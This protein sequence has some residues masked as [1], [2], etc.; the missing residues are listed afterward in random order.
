MNRQ[1]QPKIQQEK[2]YL[3]FYDPALTVFY[4]IMT[5]RIIALL[6]IY[7]ISDMAAKHFTQ[8]DLI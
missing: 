6:N 4:M 3:Y 5:A 2:K 7:F 8:D 1:N